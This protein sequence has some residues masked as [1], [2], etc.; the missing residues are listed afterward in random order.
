[1]IGFIVFLT[2]Y[3]SNSSDYGNKS[4]RHKYEQ[5]TRNEITNLIEKDSLKRHVF[6]SDNWSMLGANNKR[7]DG[8]HVKVNKN[9][10]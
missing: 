10:E 5:N 2:I 4:V 9:V 3:F 7:I 8:E 1:M 6:D